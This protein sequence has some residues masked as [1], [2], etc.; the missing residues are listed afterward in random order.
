[1]YST[2]KKIHVI[3]DQKVQQMN[4]NRKRTFYPEEYDFAINEAVREYVNS[5]YSAAYNAKHEGA[6]QSTGRYDDL[7]FLKR[8]ITMTPSY[9]ESNHRVFVRLPADY[10][11]YISSNSNTVYE[12]GGSITVGN[13][14]CSADIYSLDNLF[15]SNPGSLSL[16]YTVNKDG[17]SDTNSVDFGDEL[18]YYGTDEETRY[19]LADVVIDRLQRVGINAY[20]ENFE[21]LFKSKSIIIDNSNNR[22]ITCSFSG[23]SKDTVQYAVDKK[24]VSGNAVHIVENDFTSTENIQRL[25]NNLYES[26]NRHHNPISEIVNGRLNVYIDDDF[27]VDRIHLTYYKHPSL[28]NFRRDLLPDIPVNDSI[29]DRAARIILGAIKDSAGY[30]IQTAKQ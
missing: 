2:V 8:E 16:S 30:Q 25:L 12:R 26:K 17:G 20:Y 9:D 6:E 13:S 27:Y 11:Y 3:L 14:T 7:R 18:A 29:V 5:I 15:Y 23:W 28:L 22:G 21:Y 1:M 4:S 19:Y 10:R 24:V